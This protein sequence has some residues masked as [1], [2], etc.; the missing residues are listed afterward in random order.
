[1]ERLHRAEHGQGGG[2][3]TADG[4]CGSGSHLQC[5]HWGYR[6]RWKEAARWYIIYLLL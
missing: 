3:D 1:M 4:I 5:C 2:G 6:L